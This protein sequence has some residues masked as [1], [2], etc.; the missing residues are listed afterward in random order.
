MECAVDHR[1]PRR[2][3]SGAGPVRPLF[4]VPW[5]ARRRETHTAIP[6]AV[7]S[8]FDAGAAHHGL[9]FF[10]VAALF[11]ADPARWCDRALPRGNRWLFRI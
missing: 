11:C 6:I 9:V 5:L 3:R 4:L 2:N 10:I 8:V 1:P 7:R